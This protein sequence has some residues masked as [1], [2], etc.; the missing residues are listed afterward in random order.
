MA[1]LPSTGKRA[2]A[3]RDMGVKFPAGVVRDEVRKGKEPASQTVLSFFADA[4][5]RNG[6]R[7][8]APVP[9]R[10]CWASPARLREVAGGTYAL[11]G[12]FDNPL[13]LKGY[14]AMVIQFG[15]SPENVY[16]P[17]GPTTQ[18]NGSRPRGTWSWTPAR[19]R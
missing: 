17:R 15:S 19:T 11:A 4:W 2:A 13:P 9:P 18:I 1:T 8:T 6:P 16:T 10:N 14:G 7:C 5:G 12:E 3:Y